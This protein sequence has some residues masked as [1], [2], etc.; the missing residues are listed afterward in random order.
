MLS[1]D[2]ETENRSAIES[3]IPPIT[4]CGFLS[5]ASSERD[6]SNIHT[7]FSTDASFRLSSPEPREEYSLNRPLSRNT[8]H[9]LIDISVDS[10]AISEEVPTSDDAA[11]ESVEVDVVAVD[12]IDGVEGDQSPQVEAQPEGNEET[13]EQRMQREEEESQALVW[14]LMQ[15]DNAEMYNMQMQFMQQNSE[16]LSEEDRLLMEQLVAESAVPAYGNNTNN[17][18]NTVAGGDGEEEQGGGDEGEQEE[19]DGGE[20]RSQEDSD[21]SNWDYDRLLAL[22][23]QI[24]GK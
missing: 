14:A 12:E 20:E 9:S 1:A 5:K 6:L 8:P 21:V 2:L 4:C 22:G 11:Q 17:N 16:H 7:S 23:Q 10:S 18:G 19:E 3:N 13:A 15:Q 24:G